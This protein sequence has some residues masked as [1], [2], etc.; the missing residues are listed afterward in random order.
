MNDTKIIYDDHFYYFACPHCKQYIAVFD[1]ELNCK[2]FRCGVYKSTGQHISPHAPKKECDYL[3][4][5][6]LIYGC[7][8]PFIFKDTHVEP[9]DYI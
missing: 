1:K 5:H 4:E 6:D 2:I 3:K 7:G 8:K 9:C